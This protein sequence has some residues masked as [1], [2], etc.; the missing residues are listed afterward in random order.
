MHSLAIYNFSYS[1]SYSTRDSEYGGTNLDG[2]FEAPHYEFAD[3][4]FD[5]IDDYTHSEVA[6]ALVTATGGG[7]EESI[8]P[9][10]AIISL[11]DGYHDLTGLPWSVAFFFLFLK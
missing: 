2:G 10:H 9:V 6:E 1:R 8:L 7:G 11:L 4:G 5:K 3:R